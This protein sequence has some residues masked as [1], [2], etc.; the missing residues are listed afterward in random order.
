MPPRMLSN[1]LSLAR[2]EQPPWDGCLSSWDPEYRAYLKEQQL[3]HLA[4]SAGARGYF[5]EP[6]GNGAPLDW[7]V[8]L[9]WHSEANAERRERARTL[10]TER[11]VSPVAVSVAYALAQDFPSLALVGPRSLDELVAS[12]PCLELELGPAELAWLDLRSDRR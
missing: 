12:L 4:W 10:A 7:V 6:S 8:M 11:R 5:V 1:Q 9:I 2:M 3:P